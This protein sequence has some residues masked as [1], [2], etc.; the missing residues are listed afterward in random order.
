VAAYSATKTATFLVTATIQSSCDIAATTL[1]FGNT[2]GTLQAN[3]DAQSTIT[4][5][6]TSGTVFKVGLN[7]G[8]ATGTTLANRKLASGPAT[9]VY[10]LY[11]N[12]ARD[13][14][15][16]TI[17]TTN[18]QGGTGTGVAQ[19]LIVYGRV[20]PQPAPQPGTYTSNVTATVEY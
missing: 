11:R 6:C 12:A 10:Q 20:L 9:I 17:T 18:T 13:L 2:L 16:E 19:T 8:D 5:T 15:W 1:N 7:E 4:V 3:V 14:P